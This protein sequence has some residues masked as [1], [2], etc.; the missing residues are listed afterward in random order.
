[1]RY[2]YNTK[3][4]RCPECE[5]KFGGTDKIIV[6]GGLAR[7]PNCEAELKTIQAGLNTDLVI[8]DETYSLKGDDN[9][10]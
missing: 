9:N 10:G 8:V 3:L 2:I 4:L 7:C 5:R 1:M 6:R